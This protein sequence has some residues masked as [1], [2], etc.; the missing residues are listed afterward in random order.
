M[1]YRR[2]PGSGDIW[3]HRRTKV[4][5]EVI[6]VANLNPDPDA[7]DEFRKSYVTY[8]GTDRRVWT[9][10]TDIFVEKF[11]FS[12]TRQTL[13]DLVLQFKDTRLSKDMFNLFEYF[14][15]YNHWED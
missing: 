4:E 9:R 13:T 8:M 2:L 14:D 7:N 5:Y 10:E 1:K 11:D 3:I 12:H 6:S 15:F